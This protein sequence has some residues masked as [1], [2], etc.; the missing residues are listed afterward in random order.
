MERA[1]TILYLLLYF[2]YVMFYVLLEYEAHL[3]SYE[4]SPIY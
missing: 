1:A 2:W 4:R 3:P